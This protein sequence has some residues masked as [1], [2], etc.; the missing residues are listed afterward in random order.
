[1]AGMTVRSFESGSTWPPSGE[2]GE[3]SAARLAVA[4]THHAP[5]LGT[6]EWPAAEPHGLPRPVLGANGEVTA[7][8]ID[9]PATRNPWRGPIPTVAGDNPRP[10]P[11]RLPLRAGLTA[12][13]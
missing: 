7:V 12:R 9:K 4:G 6:K 13:P 8:S 3:L 5:T 1:M 11:S 10:G 2:A